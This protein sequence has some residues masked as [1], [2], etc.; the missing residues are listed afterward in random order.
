MFGKPVTFGDV[1]LIARVVTFDDGKDRP[2][3]VKATVSG[4]KTTYI[5]LT[6]EDG[7]TADID[8]KSNFIK[9]FE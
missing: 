2:N 7:S 6:L 5:E 4:F 3:I 1:V 8:Y 9:F